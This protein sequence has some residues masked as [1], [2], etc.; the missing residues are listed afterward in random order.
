[1]L[2]IDRLHCIKETIELMNKSYQVEILKLLMSEESIIISENN[3]G[4]FV[5]LSN[6]DIIVINKLEKFMEYVKTQQ[7]QLSHIENEKLNIKNEFF[8]KKP[9]L[10][11]IIKKDNINSVLDSK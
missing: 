6:L 8:N 7:S 5:N 4:T 9:Q 2:G 1:M 11:K 3:N 10:I